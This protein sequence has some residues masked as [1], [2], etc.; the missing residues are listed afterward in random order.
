MRHPLLSPLRYAATRLRLWQTAGSADAF[1]M[2]YPKSGRTWLRFILSN[3]FAIATPLK[4]PVTLHT[5]FSIV[6][7]FALDSVRGVPAFRFAGQIPRIYV[8]HLPYQ[9]ILFRK[10]PVILLVRDPRDV[11][12][13]SYFHAVRHKHR[14]AGSIDEFV[15]DRG[16]GLP[17]LVGY[18]NGWAGGLEARRSLVVSYEMLTA[19]PRAAVEKV[20]SF[21]GVRVEQDAL[22]QAI[23]ASSF[24]TMREHEKVGG[25]PD[26]DY[27]RSDDESLRM[28]RGKT[29]GYV[30]YL[31]PDTIGLIDRYCSHTLTAGAKRLLSHTGMDLG[32]AKG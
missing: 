3:Y 12:V 30:D 9:R 26:H 6:P 27:D 22:R 11:L 20:L 31:S 24:A 1:V 19:D 29:G 23:E 2:S 4:T 15:L 17:R 10:R 13:S 7:N 18:L 16:Q 21:L 5:M 28:R 32:G 14:F 25:I 8:S